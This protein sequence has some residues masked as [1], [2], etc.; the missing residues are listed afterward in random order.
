[1]TLRIGIDVGGTNTDAV[2]LAEDRTVLAAVKRPTT[3]DIE[4]GGRAALEAVLDGQDLGAVRQAM[5]GTTQCTNAILERRGLRR[6]GVL[7]IGAPATTAVPPLADWL[8]DLRDA[9][10]AEA[11]DIVL[12][13]KEGVIGAAHIR[14]ELGEVVGGR[15]EGRR[16]QSRVTIFKSL[17]LAVEDVAAATLVYQRARDRKAG[18]EFSL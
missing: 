3:P 7:R 6:V 5:L 9:A 10:L 4:S 8:A 14:A 18:K 16:G 17:G 11:G 2:L 15:A 12:A 1:M 13:M